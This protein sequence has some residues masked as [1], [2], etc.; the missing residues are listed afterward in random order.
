MWLADLLLLVEDIGILPTGQLVPLS[1]ACDDILSLRSV[2]GEMLLAC[3]T[4]VL[5]AAGSEVPEWA[6]LLLEEYPL[7]LPQLARLRLVETVTGT[8]ML[9]VKN[10]V[11]AA[12]ERAR[13]VAQGS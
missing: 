7:L 3:A 5:C 8:R 4:A 12:R 2:G 6:E 10:L 1:S 11:H 9:S 13:W